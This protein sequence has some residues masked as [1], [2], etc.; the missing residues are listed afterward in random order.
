M[1]DD[2]IVQLYLDRDEEAVRQT[3]EKYGPRLRAVSFKI[4][5]DRETAEECENDTYMEAWNRIPPQEPRD[6]LFA[7]LAKITRS[8]SIDRYRERKTLKRNVRIVE[9]T[10]ELEMCI[11]A[12]NDVADDVAEKLLGEA[13]SRFLLTLPDEKQIMFVRRYFYM[14]S[15]SEIARRLLIGESKVKTTL[16]RLRGE[17]RNYLVKEGYTV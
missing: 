13:I 8:L 14:D 2:K 10:D 15:I 3:S 7:F 9:L 1:E 6:Y 4:T 12:G 5:N 16:F 11:P 17:L